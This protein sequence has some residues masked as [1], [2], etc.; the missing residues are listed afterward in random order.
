MSNTQKRQ[1]KND[2]RGTKLK[3]PL[4]HGQVKVLAA[5]LN[6]HTNTLRKGWE[7]QDVEFI[8]RIGEHL[9]RLLK[10]RV[11][12]LR[13]LGMSAKEARA[14]ALDFPERKKFLEFARRRV[15]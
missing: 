5:L 3:I 6:C 4:P 8:K 9:E 12:Q 14:T 2:N 10:D 11:C 7:R 13:K 15:Q 1:P